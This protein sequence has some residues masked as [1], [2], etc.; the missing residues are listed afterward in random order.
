MEKFLGTFLNCPP[1][2]QCKYCK[3]WYK[4][5]KKAELEVVCPWTNREVPKAIDF[6]SRWER[7]ESIELED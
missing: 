1:E 2:V 5:L 7:K 6:C 3:H 4:N